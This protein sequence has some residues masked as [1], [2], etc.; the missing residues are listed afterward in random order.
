MGS[1]KVPAP[2]FFRDIPFGTV[3]PF[4]V[5]VLLIEPVWV[6]RVGFEL[7]TAPRDVRGID[8]AIG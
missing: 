2:K 5:F 4:Q 7:L 3:L 1:D 6:C 8:E